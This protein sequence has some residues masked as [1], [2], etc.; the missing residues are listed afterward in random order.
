[1]N[2]IICT[3][4]AGNH[5]T[6]YL[7]DKRPIIRVYSQDPAAPEQDCFEAIFEITGKNAKSIGMY[8]HE[9]HYREKGIPE[10]VLE[11]VKTDWGMEVFSSSNLDSLKSDVH[12]PRNRAA[13][14]VW[15]RLVNSDKAAYNNMTDQYQLL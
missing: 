15:R 6:F 2:P 9:A 7:D 13:D 4:R 8:A 1:M 3:D 11:Y 12:K 5:T 10:A 14:R